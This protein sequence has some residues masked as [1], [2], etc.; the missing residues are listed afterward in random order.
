MSKLGLLIPAHTT[1]LTV[2]KVVLATNTANATLVTVINAL[3]VS[4]V[5]VQVADITKIYCK[6]PLAALAGFAFGLF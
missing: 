4:E 5:I 3:L 1:F 6:V 2:E